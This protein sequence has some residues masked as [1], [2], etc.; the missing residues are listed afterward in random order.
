MAVTLLEARTALA[1]RLVDPGLVRWVADELDLY[2]RE[3]LRVWAALTASVRD[4]DSF[5]AT[6]AEPFADLPTVLPALRAHTLTL[7]DLIRPI[8]YQLLE[9]PT[10]ADGLWTGSARHFADTA[11]ALAVIASALVRRRDQFLGDT[12]AV[13]TRTVTAVPVPPADGRLAL[14]DDLLAIRRAA[15]RPDPT[16]ILRPLLRDDEW[17]GTHYRPAWPTPGTPLAYSTAVTPPFTVQILPPPADPGTLDLLA[18][19]RGLPATPLVLAP[20]PPDRRNP[21]RLGVPNDWAWVV[22]YG[23]LADLLAGDGLMHDPARAAYCEARWQQGVTAARSAPVVLAARINDRPV[24]LASVTDADRFSPLWQNVPGVPHTLL[25]AGQ[26]LVGLWPPPGAVLSPWT[27]TLDVV[28]NVAV[29][30]NDGDTLTVTD[31]VVDVILDYAQH[32]A[33]FKEGAGQ[34]DAAQPLFDRFLRAAGVDAGQQQ[35][36]HPTRRP[37]LSQTTQ[38]ERAAPRELS[39]Q[40]VG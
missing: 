9:P 36:E 1:A 17:S 4:T 25:T 34:L 26:T 30:V 24:R 29:P 38:D 13:L 35:A 33:T 23:A 31:D 37:L 15:W 14:G 39:P 19:R 5:T 32:A 8:Q 7:W 40:E 3:A 21:I 18:V 16:Q 6:L 11:D 27:V 20:G 10:N 22:Q 12:G 28:R 2:L